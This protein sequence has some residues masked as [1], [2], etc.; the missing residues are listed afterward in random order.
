MMLETAQNTIRR[1]AK[2]MGLD[3]K[4][5]NEL[6]E[7][8]AEHVFEIELESGKKYQGYR[9]QHNNKRGPH[10]GGIRFHQPAVNVGINFCAIILRPP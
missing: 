7:T 8:K 6:I 1:A 10:K 9:V 4:T 3:E 2:R 5:V